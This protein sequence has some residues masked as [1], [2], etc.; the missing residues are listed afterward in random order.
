MFI[1][2]FYVFKLNKIFDKAGR[3]KCTERANLYKVIHFRSERF[4]R[5]VDVGL[6]IER[7]IVQIQ[8]AKIAVARQVRIF[9]S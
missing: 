2:T 5:G 3:L 9:H 7:K 4:G 6:K 1:L 8:R